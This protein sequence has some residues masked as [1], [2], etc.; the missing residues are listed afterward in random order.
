MAGDHLAD[1]IVEAGHRGSAHAAA[2]SPQRLLAGV[3]ARGQVTLAGV[4]RVVS[5]ARVAGDQAE[6]HGAP[7]QVASTVVTGRLGLLAGDPRAVGLVFG[8][9]V[10]ARRIRLR[11]PT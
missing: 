8:V 6:D 5:V 1:G 7:K 10:R 2:R 3:M 4:D 9:G 11:Q